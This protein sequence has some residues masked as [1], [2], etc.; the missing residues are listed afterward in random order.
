M[1][2]F[3]PTMIVLQLNFVVKAY[4]PARQLS[5][6]SQIETREGVEAE[7]HIH[8]ALLR[9]FSKVTELQPKR[10]AKAAQGKT[11]PPSLARHS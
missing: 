1:C 9:V 3:D 11:Q 5:E 8:A 2:K 4:L 10:I 7:Y 6:G